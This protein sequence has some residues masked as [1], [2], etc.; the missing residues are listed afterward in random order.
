M[1]QAQG[2]INLMQGWY[3]AN[4]RKLRQGRVGVCERA[5]VLKGMMMERDEINGRAAG[6]DVN[7]HGRP[8]AMLEGETCQERVDAKALTGRGTRPELRHLEA[9]LDRLERH[10]DELILA[11]KQVH[12]GHIYLAR[13]LRA[14]TGYTF[15]RW[16]EA[17][18]AKRH[19]SWEL[20]QQM[21]SA[22]QQRTRSWYAQLSEQ[23]M[24]ANDE[25]VRLRKE[26]RS[27]K[28]CLVRSERAV[29]AKTIPGGG[30]DA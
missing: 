25:H 27:I 19:L 3:E 29:Y 16:R 2:R 30:A 21:Y 12:G 20:A 15:L 7:F 18:G 26:V 10:M 13:H 8:A 14:S 28:R 23:A 24:K 17:G 5:F 6:R 4:V 9:E 1:R 11:S 22:Y